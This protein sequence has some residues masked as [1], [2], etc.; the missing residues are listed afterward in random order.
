MSKQEIPVKTIDSVS[1]VHRLMSLPAPKNPLIT[2]INH[3]DEPPVRERG[4][5]A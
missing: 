1:E 3:A 5:I 2:L 4:F